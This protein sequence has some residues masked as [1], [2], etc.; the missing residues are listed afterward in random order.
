MAPNADTR[1]A[2]IYTVFT[3]INTHTI[4]SYID[5]LNPIIASLKAQLSR[6]ISHLIVCPFHEDT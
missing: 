2:T 5:L 3:G 1:T 4:E 6:M